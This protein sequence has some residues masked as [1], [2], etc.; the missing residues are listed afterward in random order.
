M[1]G[2]GLQLRLFNSSLDTLCSMNLNVKLLG[3]D[4]QAIVVR[5]NKGDKL[6]SFSNCKILEFPFIIVFQ[7]L[8][9]VEYL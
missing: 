1:P 9:F 8:G 3:G 7:V 4:P 2:S 5:Y 6:L